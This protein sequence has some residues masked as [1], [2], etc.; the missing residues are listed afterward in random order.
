[1]EK[2]AIVGFLL[3]GT[4]SAQQ[5]DTDPA[6][7]QPNSYTAIVTGVKNGETGER[8]DEKFWIGPLPEMGDC[9]E[10]QYV[11]RDKDT[12]GLRLQFRTKRSC[13]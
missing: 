1:M 5:M 9:V 13:D 3:I 10:L 11:G 12:G 4:A 6:K 8:M 7:K 2:I